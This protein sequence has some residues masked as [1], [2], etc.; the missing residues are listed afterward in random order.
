MNGILFLNFGLCRFSNEP[1]DEKIFMAMAKKLKDKDTGV[2]CHAA[3]ALSL[4]EVRKE[5]PMETHCLRN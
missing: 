5:D 2:R 4:T 3:I 1:L